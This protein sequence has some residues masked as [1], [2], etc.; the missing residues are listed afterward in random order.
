MR[1]SLRRTSNVNV[2]SPSLPMMEAKSKNVKMSQNVTNYL[3]E[4]NFRKLHFWLIWRGYIFAC[5]EEE[6]NILCVFMEEI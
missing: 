5:P 6:K 2:A 3:K 4:I 1:Q